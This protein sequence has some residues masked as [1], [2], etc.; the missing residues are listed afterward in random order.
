MTD[1]VIPDE[2][3]E[4]YPE[5]IDGILKSISMDDDERK[6]W[7]S[8]LPAMTDDQIQELKDILNEEQNKLSEINKNKPSKLSGDEIKNAE[9]ERARRREKRREEEMEHQRKIEKEAEDILSEL[10]SM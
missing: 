1:L 3:K 10:D 4:K 6:Y 8:V 9:E 2:L 7:I 5:I